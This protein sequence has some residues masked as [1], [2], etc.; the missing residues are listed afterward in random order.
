MCGVKSLKNNS[1]SSVEILSHCRTPMLHITYSDLILLS[2]IKQDLALS[3]IYLVT[4]NNFPLISYDS[5][6]CQN[7][8]L[9]IESKAFR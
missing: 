7:M 2:F 4:I 5:N 9:P 8:L 3:Y 6:V 1:T